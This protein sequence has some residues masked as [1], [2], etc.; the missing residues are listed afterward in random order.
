M[1]KYYPNV[2][3]F[4]DEKESGVGIITG[5]KAPH[6]IYDKLSDEAKDKVVSVGPL[7]T[8]MVLILFWLI[9]F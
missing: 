1:L 4:D 8:K 2:V 3:M 9:C 7:Y 6:L 5:W